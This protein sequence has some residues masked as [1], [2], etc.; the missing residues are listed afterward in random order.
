M[1]GGSSQSVDRRDP[2]DYGA[3]HRAAK[4]SPAVRVPVKSEND[5]FRLVFGGAV[6]IFASL[7]LGAVTTPVAGI[8]LFVGIVVGVIGWELLSK[9]PDQP[10]PLSDALDHGRRLGDAERRR[11]LVIANQTV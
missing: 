1:V 11:V 7:V 2:P 9:A 5:A 6:V 8:A 3:E 4:R 10:K